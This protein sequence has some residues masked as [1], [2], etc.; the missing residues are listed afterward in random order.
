M[1][2]SVQNVVIGG[3]VTILGIALKSLLDYALAVPPEHTKR[4]QAIELATKRVEFWTQFLDG[5][6][7]ATVAGNQEQLQAQQAAS[8][9]LER[10]KLDADLQLQRLSYEEQLRRVAMGRPH[11]LQKAASF[12][13]TQR[14]NYYFGKLGFWLFVLYALFFGSLFSLFLAKP[15][16]APFLTPIS[17]LP[18]ELILTGVLLIC[19]LFMSLYVAFRSRRSALSSQYPKPDAPILDQI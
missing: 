5:Q 2:V 4:L 12:S 1:D 6:S 10:V 14:V 18:L 8:Q 15:Q 13:S 3:V 19:L 16:P 7:K 9:A 11:H 17:N